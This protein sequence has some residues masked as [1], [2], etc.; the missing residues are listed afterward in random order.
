MLR[1]EAKLK[2]TRQTMPSTD[3]L[4]LCIQAALAEMMAA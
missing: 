2:V 1:V 4:A 3:L